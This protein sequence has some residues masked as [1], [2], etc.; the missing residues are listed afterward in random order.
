MTSP[1]EDSP[2][3]RWSPRA[4]PAEF[5]GVVIPARDEED[6]IGTCLDAVKNALEFPGAGPVRTAVVVVADQCRDATVRRARE[7]RH[8]MA[9]L[10]ILEV[11]STAASG[12]GPARRAG[13]NRALESASGCDLG[14]VW[15][16]NTDADGTVPPN[17]LQRQL[18]WYERGADAVAGTVALS[19]DD[20]ISEGLGRSYQAHVAALGL[21]DGHPHVHGANLGFTAAA[22]EAV[23]GMPPLLTGEDHAIWE[24]FKRA[25]FRTIAAGDVRVSTSG[26]LYGRA[27]HGLSHLLRSLAQAGSVASASPAALVDLEAS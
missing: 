23:G 14:R 19:A 10:E 16:A 21:G 6:R 12:A 11:H 22:Y 4:L 15:L 17:W 27:P 20:V 1:V 2:P 25:G 13:L 8:Q 5:I 26:R 9:G 7:Y 18:R 24:A 3:F